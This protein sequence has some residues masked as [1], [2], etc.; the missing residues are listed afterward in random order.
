MARTRGPT[1]LRN[2]SRSFASAS[3]CTEND[4]SPS[5][6]VGFG[7]PHSRISIFSSGMSGL[8][9]TIDPGQHDAHQHE[10]NG[11][12]SDLLEGEVER[13]RRDHMIDQVDR[14][15]GQ[16]SHGNAVPDALRKPRLVLATL[17]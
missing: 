13:H 15:D 10:T 8:C 2:A 3:R 5:T 9:S 1:S 14:N 17:Q 16:T 11:V 6:I 12:I 4:A 7:G